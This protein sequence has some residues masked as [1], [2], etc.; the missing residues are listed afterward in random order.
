[1]KGKLLGCMNMQVKPI[2]GKYSWT[3][4]ETKEKSDRE[5]R[6]GIY[7]RNE[8]RHT[9]RYYRINIYENTKTVL[10]GPMGKII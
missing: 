7:A 9:R 6:S 8:G 5:F 4:H 10:N 2:S 1:M 3:E